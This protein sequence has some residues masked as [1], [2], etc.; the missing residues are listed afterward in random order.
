MTLRFQFENSLQIRELES[1]RVTIRKNL[2]ELAEV[3][4]AMIEY[5]TAKRT[6]LEATE[7]TL[8]TETDR[9]RTEMENLEAER[10]RISER[11]VIEHVRRESEL[12]HKEAEI[13]LRTA[14]LE[15]RVTS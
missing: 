15:R 12:E 6:A 11:V 4:T 9:R 5:H 8:H 2:Q 10:L 7:L 14:E 3:E 1:Q 13:T